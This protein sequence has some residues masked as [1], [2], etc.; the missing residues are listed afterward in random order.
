MFAFGGKPDAF[1]RSLICPLMT[2][3]RLC[4][5]LLLSRLLGGT[6]TKPF[7]HFANSISLSCHS[8]VKNDL[9]GRQGPENREPAF[10]GMVESYS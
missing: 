6:L 7:G 3:W 1:S 9:S 8:L 10:L 4:R 2:H 5:T